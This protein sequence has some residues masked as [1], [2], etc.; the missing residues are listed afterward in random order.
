[1]ILVAFWHGLRASEVVGITRD[2]LADGHLTVQRLK[3][4]NR[5]TQALVSDENPLLN[6]REPLFEYSKNLLP[7]QRL[8]PISRER[9][10][11]IVQKHGA[12]AGLPKHRRH[13]HM[14]KHS[15]AMQS[16][17]SAG[18]ENVRQ[19]LGHKSIASTGEYLKVQDSDAGEAIR[20]ALQGS[21]KL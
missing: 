14:L 1:M 9:F 20:R 17:H 11:Q 21:P 2:D 19:H 8:F 10:W 4:S 3:G 18:I 16:I 7:N 6:E 12:D 15:I 13:P 5:T